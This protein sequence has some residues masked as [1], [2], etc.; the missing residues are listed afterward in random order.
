MCCIAS[1]K[2]QVVQYGELAIF[3]A[4]V[5]CKWFSLPLS[6]SLSRN[7]PWDIVCSA[8]YIEKTNGQQFTSYNLHK[9]ASVGGHFCK[10]QCYFA[11]LNT[12]ALSHCVSHLNWTTELMKRHVAI[13]FFLEIYIYPHLGFKKWR[14]KLN[15]EILS[16]FRRH[17]RSIIL[18]W[19][20]HTA[21]HLV[22]SNCYSI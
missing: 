2:S 19:K 12:P 7:F 8:E 13:D 16:R 9:H 11:K 20:W 5:K 15:S 10:Q 6:F 3:L 18:C 4:N 22:Y 17:N 1:Y 21:F 14:W